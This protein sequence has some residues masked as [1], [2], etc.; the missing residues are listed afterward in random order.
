MVEIVY[1]ILRVAPELGDVEP[2]AAPETVESENST[3]ADSSQPSSNFAGA[4]P[5]TAQ[6]IGAVE[7]STN[8][9]LGKLHGVPNPP[10]NYQPREDD[11]AQAKA[12]LLEGQ[13]RTLG[14]TASTARIGVHGMGGL[15]KTVLTAA[16]VQEEAIRQAFPDGIYW[17]TLGQEPAT[18]SLQSTL[19]TQL[20]GTTRVIESV[21]DG[22]SAL[23]E[24]LSD[25]RC[26]LVIDDAWDLATLRAFDA[27]GPQ[28][29][30]LVTTRD[31]S[32][33]TAIGAMAQPLEK[34]PL[35]GSRSLLA[36]WAKLELEQLPDA[37]N[38]V[39][40]LCDGLPLALS[41]AGAM[42]VD[43][44]PWDALVNALEQGKVA[45]LNHPY[46]SVFP[47]LTASVDRLAAGDCERYLELAV[48]D[49]DVAAPVSVV[50]SLWRHTGGL[51]SFEA[52]ALLAALAGKSLLSLKSES[53][54]DETGEVNPH[55]GQPPPRA[56]SILF[57]A[58]QH[59]YLRFRANK[60]PELH[61]AL[62]EA[63]AANSTASPGQHDWASLA[64][65]EPYLWDHAVEHLGGAGRPAD[66]E[67]LLTSPN[68][69]ERKFQARGV[70]PLLNDFHT[71]Q[72]GSNAYL[73]QRALQ[74][75]AHVISHSPNQL[76]N[77]MFGRLGVS[78]SAALD[79]FT[80]AL[81]ELTPRPRLRGLRAAH[82]RPGGA[83]LRTLSGHTGSVTGTAILSDGRR[84]LSWSS[85]HSL[86]LW[87]LEAG[88]LIHDL[89]GHQDSVQGAMLLPDGH[90]ALSW[91]PDQTLK[92]WKLEG[93]ELLRD[94]QGHQDTVLGAVLLD[95]GRSALSWSSDQTLRLW[96]LEAGQL[97]HDLQ[98]H[99]KPVSGAALLDNGRHALSWSDDGALK[100]WDLD[101]GQLL[102]DL[103]GHLDSVNGAVL[104]D[105]GR[106]A[107]SWS[108]D[109]TI[110]LWD[111]EAGRPLLDLQG[112]T[113][114]VRG[115]LLLDDERRALS[116]SG[117]ETLKLWDLDT[118]QP[119][120]TL[121]GHQGTV[122]GALLLDDGRRALSWSYDNTI[123]LW[124]LET[125]LLLSDCQGHQDSA[126]S[127][128]LL[129]DGRRALS[130][131]AEN[132]LRLWNLDAGQLLHEFQ[133][134][135]ESVEGA[136]LLDEG[137]RAL[138]WSDDQ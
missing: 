25:K 67:R 33:L 46:G 113:G 127:S 100:L 84:A 53:L 81:Y 48:F 73:I 108:S 61:G 90:H 136:L 94:L 5:S 63:L 122:R 115:I 103:Q 2:Q 107:L 15:G 23:R 71:V 137:R 92:L 59:D 55:A 79:E 125:G 49:E 83:E 39:A 82:S 27:A 34:L 86:K 121:Q 109:E 116:W 56:A 78:G 47:S 117:D 75:S 43:K 36:A 105:G 57:H 64:V 17:I 37:A 89:Q 16:L 12:A 28:G 19:Y 52:D 30:T 14:I 21:H 58:L 9:A 54:G 128:L 85:D 124:D 44:V 87:D 126:R 29:A 96:D 10:P 91:S 45:F 129:D 8:G 1:K 97:R 65:A 114:N 11:L 68:W 26:L 80:E 76:A 40:E 118:G 104:L 112:H 18:L 111:L 24:A 101:A 35:A 31:A 119:L 77:Q 120:R 3:R 99:Q 32:L 130:W 7:H 41:V 69:V 135:Q 138:S 106:R 93:G 20:A 102:L 22:H 4:A 50:C 98:G 132:T 51:E 62:L 88:Q 42:A 60:L 95:D 66:V 131:S 70:V 133:G 6:S 110:K 134:H 123:K 13:T 38:K 74:M 72:A